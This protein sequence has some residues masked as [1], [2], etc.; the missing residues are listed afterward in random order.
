MH[1]SRAGFHQRSTKITLLHAV[2]FSPDCSSQ[3]KRTSEATKRHTSTSSLERYQ[4]EP[5]R[6]ARLDVSQRDLTVFRIHRAIIY[7]SEFKINL[8]TCKTTKKKA[9]TS[10]VFDAFLLEE[11]LDQIQHTRELGENDRLLLAVRAYI[12]VI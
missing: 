8:T 9:P 7:T 2:K 12:Y 1:T 6:R 5:R 10:H 3:F 4:Y 11:W